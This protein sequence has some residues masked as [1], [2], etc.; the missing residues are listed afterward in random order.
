[1]KRTLHLIV[2]AALLLITG[3]VAGAE[4]SASAGDD[5]SYPGIHDLQVMRFRETGHTVKEPFLRFYQAHGGEPLFGQPLTEE[6]IMGGRVVQFF[7]RVVF[8]R[9]LESKDGPVRLAPIAIQMGKGEP[10]LPSSAIPA[11]HDPERRYFP[12][13]GHAVCRA[14]LSFLEAHGGT[15]LFGQPITEIQVEEGVIV[16][17]FENARLEREPMDTGG[18][19]VR[20]GRLAEEYLHELDL[21]L[22]LL[23]PVITT[24]APSPAT[25]LPTATSPMAVEMPA[26]PT[27]TAPP[28]PTQE[29]KPTPP[30]AQSDPDSPP[31][32]RV[33]ADG[34]ALRLPLLYMTSDDIGLSATVRHPVIGQGGYQRVH[35]KVQDR[36]GKGMAGVRVNL[37]IRSPGEDTRS[38]SA[39]SDS[40]GRASF[41][42]GVGHPSPG[43]PVVIDV[44]A[45]RGGFQTSTQIAF[46]CW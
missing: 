6:F 20:I 42:F 44:Q 22:S 18:S 1:M 16:Q 36:R 31:S 34:S 17:Y 28:D 35:V 46:V 25:A 29:P 26:S 24:P 7:E 39:Y 10:P 41:V 21:P 14:F 15:E 38:L 4:G 3:R 8:A 40:G 37:V 2:M 5:T 19:G 13:T 43:T 45:I 23:R 32:V 33:P 27:W 11:P 12:E 9:P 30:S